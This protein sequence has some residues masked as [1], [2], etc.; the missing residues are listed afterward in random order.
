LIPA[1]EKR[2]AVSAVSRLSSRSRALLLGIVARL[3]SAPGPSP[4]CSSPA[5]PLGGLPQAT[6]F[7]GGTWLLWSCGSG[8]GLRLNLSGY[9]EVRPLPV[10]L[11]KGSDWDPSAIQATRANLAQLPGGDAVELQVADFRR[12]AGYEQHTILC[13]P[14]YGIR[15]GHVVE[16]Q[17]LY[18]ELGDFLKTRCAGSSAFVYAGDPSL[19]KSVGLRTSARRTLVNGALRGRLCR[20]DVFEGSW[21]GGQL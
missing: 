10:G 11:L 1:I 16:A 2:V 8:F 12:L 7:A 14:P 4:V 18:R 6:G 20:F 3:T 5:G 21:H 19:I 15:L 13:N 9:A 17:R